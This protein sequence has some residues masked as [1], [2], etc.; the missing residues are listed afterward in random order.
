MLLSVFFHVFINE[1]NFFFKE[2]IFFQVFMLR[3]IFCILTIEV[4]LKSYSQNHLIKRWE[5]N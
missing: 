5:G 3:L 1:K 2:L 4:Y